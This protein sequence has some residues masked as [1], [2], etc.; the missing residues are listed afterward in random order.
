MK[1]ILTAFASIPYTST[2]A[3]FEHYFQ[4]VLYLIFTLLGKFII[5]E[6]HTSQGRADAISEDIDSLGIDAHDL[7]AHRVL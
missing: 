7:S 1:D 2:T 4:S 5:C 3:P 6:L